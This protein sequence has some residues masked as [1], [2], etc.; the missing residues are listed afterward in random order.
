MRLRRYFVRRVIVPRPTSP[1]PQEAAATA[2]HVEPKIDLELVLAPL[3]DAGAPLPQVSALLPN[4][5]AALPVVSAPLPDAGAPPRI[6]RQD[7]PHRAFPFHRVHH[8]RPGQ[9][10]KRRHRLAL[11]AAV[12]VN[13][14][15]L[16]VLAAGLYIRFAPA[17]SSGNDLRSDP[18]D[19]KLKATSTAAT[20]WEAAPPQSQQSPLEEPHVSPPPP[21]RPEPEPSLPEVVQPPP[22][23]PVP[24]PPIPAAAVPDQPVAAL[25]TPS[26]GEDLRQSCLVYTRNPGET[27]MLRTWKML[28]LASAMTAALAVSPIAF[29]QDPKD[30]KDKETTK[31]IVERID[32]LERD[33]LEKLDK[34]LNDKMNQTLLE[35]IRLLKTSALEKELEYL[36]SMLHAK[37]KE[38]ER[39]D[40]EMKQ[41][42]SAIDGIKKKIPAE[43]TVALYPPDKTLEEIKTRLDQIEKAL[44]KQPG[45]ERVANFPP[46]MG[47]MML[48]NKY[49]EELLFVV[50]G[51]TYRVGPN[52]AQPLE[53]VPP[54]AINYEVISPT[55]GRRAARSTSLSANET[56]T[57]TAQ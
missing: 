9:P 28:K 5:S 4:V 43:G 25:P 14:L 38:F 17:K 31:T 6:I 34:A 10:P 24:E 33:L 42:A 53:N 18:A 48:V 12:A 11:V 47:R 19:L 1:A 41:L 39:F 44:G 20:A 52:S 29:G 54:G 56:L 8:H 49:P 51:R 32:K 27:P 3:P 21:V 55:W 45:Q 46:N 22:L 7:P 26:P 50:N 16:V 37:D 40:K 15:A 36:R 30:S 13:A 57:L 2:T 23:V 35:Q